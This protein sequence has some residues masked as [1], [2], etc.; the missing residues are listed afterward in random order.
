MSKFNYLIIS[1]MVSGFF[2]IPLLFCGSIAFCQPLVSFKTSQSLAVV[3]FL[4][5]AAGRPEASRT[6]KEYIRNTLKPEDSAAFMQM[7]RS[8]QNIQLE[9]TYVFSQYPEKRQRPHSTM[10]LVRIAAIQADDVPRFLQ[11]IAGMMPNKAWLELS[12]VMPLAAGYYESMISAKY[13]SDIQT[14]IRDLRKSGPQMDE[15]FQRINRFYGSTWQA[16]QPFTVAV[17][18]IPGEKGNTTA[19]PHANSLTLGVMTGGKAGPGLLGVVAH[20]IGHVLYDEQEISV[21]EQLEKAFDES[22]SPYASYARSYF[23]EALA[24]ATGNGWAYEFLSGGR[25]TSEWYNDV[26]IDRFGKGIYPMVKDYIKR[27]AVIDGGFVEEAIRI[28]ER[29]I[30]EAL[31]SYDNLL[32]AVSFYT[33]ANDYQQYERISNELHNSFRISSI[34]SS[35]PILHQI[36]QDRMQHSTETQ[37]LIVYS[38]HAANFKSLKK[39]FPELKKADAKKE[40]VISFRQKSGRPVIVVNVRD[41]SRVAPAIRK[42]ASLKAFSPEQPFVY[43]DDL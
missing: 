40:Q 24:T 9:Y 21:Q 34:N 23:D 31:Y 12:E 29:E 43:L 7:V 15:V 17:F 32:N 22:T 6:Y 18:G 11:R 37:L 16:K 35:F 14:Q 20:E 30:P 10:D 5:A 41:E 25:D 2:L 42:M 19:S 27:G 26:Y 13:A 39:I 1:Y 33:D 4:E 3:K 8:F 28:F 36:S 38:D